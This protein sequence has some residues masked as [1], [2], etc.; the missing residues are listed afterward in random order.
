MRV[1]R[2]YRLGSDPF[3]QSASLRTGLV[4]DLFLRKMLGG[5]G[6]MMRHFNRLMNERL[7]SDDRNKSSI[8]RKQNPWLECFKLKTAFG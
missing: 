6:V 3:K 1:M 2:R 5:C 8:R 4:G 7:R